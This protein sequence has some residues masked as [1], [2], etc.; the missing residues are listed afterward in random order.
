M[1]SAEFVEAIRKGVYEVAIRGMLKDIEN[2]AGRKVS[3]ERTAR[4][5]WFRSLDDVQR[6]FVADTIADSVDLAVHDFL[7]V[8]DGAMTIDTD[9]CSRFE[10]RYVSETESTLLNPPDEISF[11]E[12]WS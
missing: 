7:C 12:L 8:L 5:D 9:P 2:P 1:N 6:K 10:V 4:A 11:Y 3:P